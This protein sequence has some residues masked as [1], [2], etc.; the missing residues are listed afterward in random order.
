MRTKIFI[1][2]SKSSSISEYK[3]LLSVKLVQS[4]KLSYSNYEVCIKIEVNPL[5]ISVCLL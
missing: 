4:N 2:A 3:Y 1:I 5:K